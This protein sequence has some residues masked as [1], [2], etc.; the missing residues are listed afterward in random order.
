MTFSFPR[1][2]PSVLFCNTDI[3]VIITVGHRKLT[4]VDHFGPTLIVISYSSS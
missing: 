3:L 1:L 4:M 2:S